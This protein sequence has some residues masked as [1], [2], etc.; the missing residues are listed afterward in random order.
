MCVHVLR[1]MSSTGETQGPDLF[2]VLALKT[3]V[4]RPLPCF[5]EMLTK[6]KKTK[7]FSSHTFYYFS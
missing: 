5:H 1:F 3:T 4:L 2:M 6:V 7:F